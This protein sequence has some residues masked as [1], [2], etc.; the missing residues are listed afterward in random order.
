MFERR[1]VRG[2]THSAYMVS[3]EEILSMNNAHYQNANKAVKK[4]NNPSY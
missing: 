3:K 2:N 1:V 4:I